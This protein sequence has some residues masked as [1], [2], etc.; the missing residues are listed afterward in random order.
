MACNMG[1]D[2]VPVSETT[3]EGLKAGV[4]SYLI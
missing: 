3:P 4:G 1:E 2:D